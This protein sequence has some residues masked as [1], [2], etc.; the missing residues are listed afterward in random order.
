[1]QQTS[2]PQQGQDLTPST[3]PRSVS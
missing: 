3:I 1:L 2:V